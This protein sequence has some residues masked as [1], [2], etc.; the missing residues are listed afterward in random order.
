MFRVHEQ[1][2]L[3][4]APSS[5]PAQHCTQTIISIGSYD[6]ARALLDKKGSIYS[7]RPRMVM[8]GELATRGSVVT[9]PA[10]SLC[11][12]QNITLEMMRRQ[13]ENGT[14]TAS[15]SDASLPILA[16]LMLSAAAQ[17][18]HPRKSLPQAAREPDTVSTC[19]EPGIELWSS[20][21]L[22]R[23]QS[24]CWTK[25]LARHAP[26]VQEQL[27]GNMHPSR[28]LQ[29]CNVMPRVQESDQKF[30][31]MADKVVSPLCE[32]EDVDGCIEFDD[33]D[34]SIKKKVSCSAQDGEEPSQV[35]QNCLESSQG[36]DF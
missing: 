32:L 15:A 3:L 29:G 36:P 11:I 18:K 5:G 10:I 24:P 22:F 17:N 7:S 28:L 26:R 31:D 16:L 23:S 30:C 27:R 19:S 14:A 33:T 12:R 8:A 21:M 35:L 6:V 25:G 2:P 9:S 1:V 20:R 4:L 13:S 34:L